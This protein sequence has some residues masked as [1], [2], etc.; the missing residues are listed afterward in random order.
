MQNFEFNVNVLLLQEQKTWVAQCLE[1]DI[2][3]QGDT[4]N[5][6]MNNFGRTFLGQVALDFSNQKRP[7]EGIEPSPDF[8]WEKFKKARR[9]QDGESFNLPDVPPAHIVAGINE[10]RISA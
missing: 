1:Y 5:D 6:A 3:A 8:Y 7:L 10:L 4:I 9:L 2:A